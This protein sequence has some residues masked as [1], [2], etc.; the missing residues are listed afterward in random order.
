MRLEG[1]GRA[2]SRGL[3]SETDG[4]AD[5]LRSAWA[6]SGESSFIVLERVLGLVSIDDEELGAVELS[7]VAACVV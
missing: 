7:V 3:K 6:A 1:P 2:R 5:Q 4:S